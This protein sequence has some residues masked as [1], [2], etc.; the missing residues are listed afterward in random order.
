MPQKIYI[1]E[2]IEIAGHSRARYMHH[3]T[4]NWVPEAIRER[5]QRCFG[6][7]AS[8]G[9][10]GPWPQVVNLWELDDW[11]GLASNFAV[12]LA[13]PNRQDPTLEAWWEQAASLR[14]GGMDRIC[15]PEVWTKSIDELT[16]EG[17]SGACYVHEQLVG[18]PGT[19][20]DALDALNSIGRDALAE[21]GGR[22]FAGFDVAMRN[23]TEAISLAAF[24]ALQAWAE[25]EDAAMDRQQPWRRW[26]SAQGIR[27]ERILLVDAPLSP[28]R[29]GRQPQESDRLPL[30]QI[31]G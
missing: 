16:T 2:F 6:V 29:I 12:E 1:H 17:F 26:L 3:M 23:G 14:R 15:V 11:A 30:E 8:V 28:L 31:S 7:F 20:R 5:N 27:Q 9:S 24:D 4:A 19:S 25:Y 22:L 13:R 21:S 18:P 10:T